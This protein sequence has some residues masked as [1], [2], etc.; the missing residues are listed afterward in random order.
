MQHLLGSLSDL[1]DGEIRH[2]PGSVA[3]ASEPEK[4]K[5][6]PPARPWHRL[7][8]QGRRFTVAVTSRCPDPDGRE[9]VRHARWTAPWPAITTED[10]V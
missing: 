7:R 9:Q 6:M 3:R 2:P 8:R 4:A 5:G 1:T 10:A